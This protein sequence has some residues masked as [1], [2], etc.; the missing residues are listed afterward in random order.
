MK[1]TYTDTHMN[2]IEMWRYIRELVRG[3]VEVRKITG[4]ICTQHVRNVAITYFTCADLITTARLKHT[5][6]RATFLHNTAS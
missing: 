4:W 3:I 5:S 1:F 2:M 6:I